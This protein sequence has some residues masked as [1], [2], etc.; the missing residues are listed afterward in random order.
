MLFRS[1]DMA[2][3]FD[4]TLAQDLHQVKGELQ[5]ST[6]ISLG[7]VSSIDCPLTT[8]GMMVWLNFRAEFARLV[9]VNEDF[10]QSVPFQFSRADGLYVEELFR[11]AVTALGV[12]KN[13]P[14]FHYVWAIKSSFKALLAS[15]SGQ[16]SR[17]MAFLGNVVTHF[18]SHPTLL[19]LTGVL[20]AQLFD[21]LFRV[22]IF[23][24]DISLAS[25]FHLLQKELVQKY[26]VSAVVAEA[27]A[28]ILSSLQ[29]DTLSSEPKSSVWLSS[30]EL[31]Q[32]PHLS[33]Y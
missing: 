11:N 17:A 13:A 22:A 10:Q 16:I 6:N 31:P 27:Q 9:K 1:L 20:F 28:L 2:D 19:P 12:I 25:S 18:E 33:P 26:P 14:L 30:V 21:A 4:R 23:Y 24:R 29:C 3:L 8:Q 32:L 5:R 15:S 7:V